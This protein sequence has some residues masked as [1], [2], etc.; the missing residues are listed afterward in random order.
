MPLLRINKRTNPS[1]VVPI[2]IA[3]ACLLTIATAVILGQDSG[4][5][6][7][8]KASF[9]S[10]CASC[11][12]LD[13]RGGE[14][15]P[16]IAS[17]PEVVHKT[18]AELTEILQ[19][20]KTASG[21]PAFSFLGPA[22]ISALVAYLRTLQG[23]GSA[24]SLP[25]NPTQGKMLFFGKA[26]CGECHMVGGQ[27]G[28]FARDLSVFAARLSAEEVRNKIFNPDK[29]LDPRRGMVAVVL[30]DSSTISG[31]VRNEDNFS[32][33]LQTP[34]G[35]FH[36]LNKSYIRS[37]TYAGK[38]AMPSNYGA[39]LTAAELNDIVSYLLR[40]SAPQKRSEAENNSED[41]DDN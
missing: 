31:V 21:M 39:T 9:G 3:L 33:Q 34:D 11:H 27:G 29:D 40:T 19:S 25:G 15:G 13:A 26:N 23:R 24:A 36:L 10:I 2:A 20:G 7:E 17:R 5:Q 14:R 35:A 18:D 32:L 37:Q 22:K 6:I 28:F 41:H 1:A 12:G 8:A 16:D 4:S 30:A 38:S